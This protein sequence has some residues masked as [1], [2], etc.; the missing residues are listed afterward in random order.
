MPSLEVVQGIFEVCFRGLVEDGGIQVARRSAEEI[1]SDFEVIIRDDFV[2]G[3]AE[4]IP[5]TDHRDSLLDKARIEASTGNYEL[6]VTLYATWIEH[7]V[8]GILIRAIERMGHGAKVGTQIIRKLDLPVKVTAFWELVGL[9]PLPP[10]FLKSMTQ[11]LERRNAFVHYKWPRRDDRG[12]SGN[13]TQNKAMMDQAEQIAADLLGVESVAFWNGR[14][15]EL[16]RE[17]HEKVRRRYEDEP[18]RISFQEKG[19]PR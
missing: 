16:I 13:I 15:A 9:P 7:S 14:D 18:P 5:V 6:A 1:L 17:L 4:I 12:P 8:N 2:I 11:V 10:E 3:E 19:E